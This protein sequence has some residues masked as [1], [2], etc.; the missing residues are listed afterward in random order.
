ML[1]IYKNINTKSNLSPNEGY[2]EFL[3]LILYYKIFKPRRIEHYL[4]REIAWGFIQSA[5][6]LRLK[7]FKKYGELFDGE[8]EYSQDTA[9][10]SYFLLKTY[11]LFYNKYQKCIKLVPGNNNVKCFKDINLRQKNFGKIINFCIK[12]YDP[13]DMSM[14]FSLT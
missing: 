12:N 10:L 9:L 7:G 5:K 2:T 3:A 14:K 6:I 1:Y 13:E 4:T 11:F 8:K